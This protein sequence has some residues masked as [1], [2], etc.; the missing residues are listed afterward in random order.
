MSALRRY[1]VAGLLIWVPLGVTFLVI[2]LLIDLMDRT[3]VLIPAPYRPE[4]LLGFKIP[5]LGV[6]LTVLVVIVTGMIFANLFGRR[7]VRIWEEILARIPL[8]RWIYSSVKQITET[9]FSAKGKSFR[10][11]VLVEYPRRDLWTLA[12]VTG[13]TAPMLEDITGEDLV[14]IY[15]PTTPNP[16]SGFFLMVPKKDVIELEMSV[17]AGLKMILS[18]GVVIP[19]ADQE[20]DK[21]PKVAN[22]K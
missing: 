4:N 18:T 7:L 5:G 20:P 16:T 3:L 22:I 9:L 6:A 14:N 19:E 13:D 15:V 1:I 2:K 17:E 11:V 12:F 8:V 21:L 10:K